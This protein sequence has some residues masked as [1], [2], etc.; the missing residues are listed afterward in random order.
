VASAPQE[1]QVVVS[2]EAAEV[3][4]SN[5]SGAALYASRGRQGF[6]CN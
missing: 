3:I 5:Y 1:G 4:C 6:N 2:G